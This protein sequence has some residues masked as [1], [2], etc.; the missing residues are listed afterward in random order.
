MSLQRVV[1]NFIKI[2]EVWMVEGIDILVFLSPS[3]SVDFLYSQIDYRNYHCH[4]VYY[5]P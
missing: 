4:E 2:V 5:I 3:I 1:M